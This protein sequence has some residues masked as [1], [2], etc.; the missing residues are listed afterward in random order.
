MLFWNTSYIY[1]TI[2]DLKEISFLYEFIIKIVISTSFI[3]ISDNNYINFI[4]KNNI[5]LLIQI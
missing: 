5:F 2:S 1:N 3:T 4:Y